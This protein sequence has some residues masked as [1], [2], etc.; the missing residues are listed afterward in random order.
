M[1][2]RRKTR[3]IANS[4]Y[5]MGLERARL[6]DLTGAADCLKKSLHFNKYQTDARNLLGLIYYEAG[7]V[8]EALVQWVISKNL[9][10]EGN[11]RADFYLDEIQRKRGIMDTERQLVRRFNQAFAYAQNGSEDLAILQLNKVVEAKPNYVKAQLLLGLLC[12]ARADY[13]KAGKAIYTVLQIDR[14]NPRALWYKAELKENAPAKREKDTE[15]RRLKNVV[16]HRQMEDDD[17]I[18]PPSYKENTRDQAVINILVGLILGAAVIFFLVQPALT[19]ANNERHNQEILKYSEQLSQANVEI[20]RLTAEVEDLNQQ[21]QSVEES[22]A[23]LTNDSNSVLAQYQSVIE[24][25]DAYKDDDFN[26]AVPIYASLDTS[27]ITSPQVL[28][29]LDEIRPDMEA[30][31]YQVLEALGDQASAQGNQPQALD[32]YLKSLNLNPNNWQVKYKVA[33]IYKATDQREQANS[34]FTDIIDNSNDEQ[35]AAQARQE[36]GF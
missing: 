28:A 16:S 29:V 32:Y 6:R 12:L 23:S 11:N 30:N 17:V 35:L 18:I 8:G 7:E 31:G 9:Q 20:D 22:L 26:R 27:L 5:N 34:L 14:N 25:L 2:Y 3:A 36:R 4:Y 1:D 21:N 19:K 15:R 24:I 33:V 10:P 13:Q